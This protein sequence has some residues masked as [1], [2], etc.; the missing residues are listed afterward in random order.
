MIGGNG[1]LYGTNANGGRNNHGDV[2]SLD[3]PA[4][5]GGEWKHT[6]IWVADGNRY[7]LGPRAGLVI[8][9][10]NTLYATAYGGGTGASGL[11]FSLT[12]PTTPG[13]GWTETILYNFPAGTGWH[14]MAL[15]LGAGGALYGTTN[16]GRPS[17]QG[18]T[19]FSLTPPT[20]Q[21][22]PW[23]ETTLWEFPTISREAASS[24]IVLKS[25]E[26]NFRPALSSCYRG[27]VCQT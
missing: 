5:P 6:E 9:S 17:K 11:V 23:T 14:P 1:G 4:A 7:G 22:G 16:M 19:I 10:G 20:S 25:R 27:S 18:G 21:G 13:A 15:S 2:Y 26:A 24:D 3:P 12:P 8:G